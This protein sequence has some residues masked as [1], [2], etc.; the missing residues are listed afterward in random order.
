MNPASGWS[1]GSLVDEIA[2]VLRE[3][4][5]EGRYAAGT[6]LTQRGLAEDLS[7]ARA[8]VGE[9]LRALRR[10]GLVDL[11]PGAAG[12]RVAAPDRPVFLSAYE[13]REVLDG[14]GA[15]LAAGQIGPQLERRCREALDEQRVALSSEDGLRYMRAN[16]SFHARIIDGSG[17]PLLRQHLW[18]VRSTGRSAVALGLERMRQAVEEHET[19]LA[20]VSG[21][22]PER[23]ERVARAH[24]RATIEALERSGDF[25]HR[26]PREP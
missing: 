15:R 5:I 9:A 14:L 19:I 3:R 21:G 22:E 7:V 12:T 20:A 1:G 25:P 18:L 4:I 8:V 16:V 10:E 17:S 11:A 2:D 6:L 23:A 13:M 24:V 26:T